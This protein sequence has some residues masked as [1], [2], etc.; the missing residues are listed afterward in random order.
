MFPKPA[1][2][3]SIRNLRLLLKALYPNSALIG[4]LQMTIVPDTQN[5]LLPL[6]DGLLERIHT[7]QN[8]STM[9]ELAL[10]IRDISRAAHITY[11]FLSN[12]WVRES[13]ELGVTTYPMSWQQLYT[14]R[15]LVHSDPVVRVALTNALPFLWSE[16]KIL[17]Q[18]EKRVMQL[19]AEQDLGKDGMSI[20]LR[21]L[22][23]ELGLLTITSRSIDDFGQNRR[24]V[25]AATFSQIGSYIHEWFANYGGRR[26]TML[27]PRL[28]AR[29]RECLAYHGE[30]LMTQE[31]SYRLNISEAT[32]R[33][34]LATARHKL[35]SQTTCGAVAKAIKFGLI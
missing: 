5:A 26:D 25:Y 4:W 2:T 1:L 15:N 17:S 12:P 20:P 11:H 28:S 19:F 34:Y 6:G 9:Q 33:L 13:G 31:V 16:I 14:E 8:I 7:C 30:G 29:E 21:G 32:V 24:G 23:G 3:R 27:P 10:E 35:R 18:K 22:R